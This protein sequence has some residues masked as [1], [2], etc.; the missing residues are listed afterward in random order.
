MREATG[1][2]EDASVVRRDVVEMAVRRGEPEVT[3]VVMVPG[4]NLGGVPGFTEDGIDR[5]EAPEL[6]AREALLVRNEDGLVRPPGPAC[7]NPLEKHN[8][9]VVRRVAERTAFVKNQIRLGGCRIPPAKLVCIDLQ[10]LH[11]PETQ[12]HPEHSRLPMSGE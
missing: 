10:P 7:E 12:R 11:S 5:S 4:E 3:H 8:Q 1:E 9:I 2:V 6:P